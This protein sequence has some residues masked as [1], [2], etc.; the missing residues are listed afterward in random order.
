MTQL[1]DSQRWAVT[2]GSSQISYETK[3]TILVCVDSNKRDNESA[4]FIFLY[5]V[6]RRAWRYQRGNQTP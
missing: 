4:I 6:G 5:N 1:R 3:K 2:V